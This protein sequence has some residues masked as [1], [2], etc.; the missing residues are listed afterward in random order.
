[1]D[2]EFE[3]P[4]RSSLAAP[5]EKTSQHTFGVAITSGRGAGKRQLM[6]GDE[7][8]IGKAPTNHLCVD[9][10]T[11]SRFHCVIERTPRGLL[12]RDLNSFNGTLVA[13]CWVE[14][15]FL[16]HDASIRIGQTTLQVFRSEVGTKRAA[17]DTNGP[18]MLGTSPAAQRLISVIPQFAQTGATIL[19]EGETGTGKSMIA[20]LIHQMGHRA[21]GPFIVVDAGALA[22]SLIESELFGHEKGSFTGATERR[23]GA[24]EAAQGGTL[25][26]DEVGELPLELQPKLLRALEERVIRRLGSTQPVRLD[27][28]IIAATNRNLQ[29]A[30]A[31]GRFRADLYYRLETLRLTVPPLRDRREDIPELVEHFCRRT[32]IEVDERKLDN[33]KVEFARR[34]WPGN[35]RELRNAVERSVL[36]GMLKLD[37]GE[38]DFYAVIDETQGDALAPINNSREVAPFRTAKESAVSSWEKEYLTDLMKKAEGNLSLA[39]RMARVDRGHLRDLLRHHEVGGRETA[40]LPVVASARSESAAR[41]RAAAIAA[42]TPTVRR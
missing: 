37:S 22:A 38:S 25:F 27:V 19:L 2:V 17:S 12:I 10:P 3:T 35:I 6:V 13:G 42:C 29:Q 33:L 9:D 20:E 39:A 26:L 40:S 31:A 34:P 14:S 4:T 15:A 28:Q 23:L 11:V 8:R 16:A 1:M 24:F 5:R 32:R 18:R 21:N 30:V 7:L 36:M 41:V